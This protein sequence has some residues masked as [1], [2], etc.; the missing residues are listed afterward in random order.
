MYKRFMAFLLTFTLLPSLVPGISVFAAGTTVQ[1]P[2]I[3][4]DVPDV[5]IIRVGDAYYMTST[6]MHMNP[7]VPIMKSTDLVNWEIVNYAYDILAANDKQALLNG[8]NEYGQGS[9]ASALRYNKGKFYIV[10]GSLATGKSYIFQTENIEK[11]PWTSTTLNQYYHDPSLLFD[12]DGRVY[13]IYGGGDIWATE[14]TPDATAIKSGGLNKVIIPNASAAA[15]GWTGKGLNAE[16]SH[17]QKINGKYYVFNI[18]W[19]EG[20]MRTQ[21]VH[22]ADS[23]DGT[24]EGKT[25]LKNNGIAQGGI[26]DTPDG[27]WYGVLFKDNGAV[28]RIPYIIPATWQDGWPVFGDTQDTG[29]ST[30]NMN[31][32]IVKSDEFN[33]RADKVGAYHT[34]VNNPQTT[35][36]S[37]TLLDPSK[38][39]KLITDGDF[40]SGTGSW[41]NFGSESLSTVT[42]NNGPKALFVTGRTATGDGPKQDVTGSVY[43]GR[44]YNFSAKIKYGSEGDATPA[45]KVFNFDLEANSTQA[46]P[47]ESIIVGSGTINKGEWGTISGTITI[48]ADKSISNPFIFIETPWTA[49]PDANNDLMNFYVDDVSLVDTSDPTNTN[50]IA[51]SDFENGNTDSW[52][53]YG[54]A[55]LSAVGGDSSYL[56]VTDRNTTAGP[57]HFLN[58]IQAGHTY[59][60]STKVKYGSDGDATPA[61]KDFLFSIE[62]NSKQERPWESVLNKSTTMTKGA[63]GTI[64]G[65]FTIPATASVDTPFIFIETPWAAT[66]DKNN[67]L[68]DFCVDDI[69]FVDITPDPNIIVNG[70][71]ENGQN[72]WTAHDNNVTLSITNQMYNSGTNSILASERK[73]TA[74]SP[75]QILTGKLTAGHKYH[76]SA[77]VRYD[78]PLAPTEKKFNMDF[79]DG[80]DWTTIKVM[81]SNT[82]KKGEWGTIEGNYTIPS[83]QTLVAPSIFFETDW[84]P[85]PDPHNDLMDF[86]ID[87]VSMIDVTPADTEQTLENESN[88]SN[89]DLVWQWNHNPDNTKWSLTDRPG[90][91]RITTG[92]ISNDIHNAKNTLTQ[93]TFGPESS[94]SIAID[95]SNMKDGDYAGLAAF[96]YYY[97]YVGVKMSGTTK[98]IVMVRG[99]SNDSNVKS[100][101]VEVASIPIEQNR[102]YFKVECD[103][104]NMADN[105][106]FYYSLDGNTWTSIGEPLHMNYYSSHFMGYRFG[107]FNYATKTI[108]GYVDFDY[109]RV[110]NKMTGTT[111]TTALN[112]SLADVP[113]VTGAQNVEFT[114]PVK[115]DALPAGT[116]SSIAVPLNIP[117]YLTVTGVDFNST[118]ITGTTSYT[119]S[120]NQLMLNVSGSNVN[121]A[122]NNSDNLFA[123]IKLKVALFV[124]IDTT[125][126]IT[127]D[128]INVE[129]GDVV[130]NVNNA[131]AN[132]E[133]KALNTGAIEKVPGYANPLITH[134]YGADPYA[135]VYNGRV[136]VYMTSDA[137]E[138]NTDGTIKQNSYSKINTITV[139][140]S[141]DMVNW[142]DHGEIPVAGPNGVAKWAG[143]S[144]APAA[145]HKTINGKEKF[146]LYFANPGDGIGVLTAD[147]P[148]GPWSDPLGHTMVTQETP[149]VAG[150]TWLFDPAVLVDDDGTGYLYV[151]GGVPNEQDPASVA[152]PKTTRVLKLGDDMISIVGNAQTIDAPYMFEDSGIH[153]YNGKYYYSYCI[154][155]SLTHPQDYPIANI[156]YM[157]SDSPMGPFTYAGHFLKNPGDFFGIVGNNHHSVFQF[158]NQW[159]VIYHSQNLN[160]AILGVDKGYRSSNINKLEY[161][162][163]GQIK[164]VQG[165]L[166]GAVQIANVDPYQRTEA[167]TIAW[168]KGITTEVSSAADG[169]VSNL[170]V[171]GIDNGDWLAVSNAD[172]GDNGAKSFKAN[173]AST[174]GGKIEI[175]LDSPEGQ[176]IGT[177]NV[178]PTGGAQTWQ[179]V[180]TDVTDVKGVHSIFF[181]F[182]GAG[183]NLFN[184]DYWQFIKAKATAITSVQ[185]VMDPTS[186]AK[187]KSAALTLTVKDQ[188]GA[189]MELGDATVAYTSGN[190][191]VAAVYNG[192]VTGIEAGI[193]KITAAVTTTDGRV[194]ESNPVTVEVLPILESVS[195]S[196]SKSLLGT[197]FTAQ[198]TVKGTMTGDEQA[199]LSKANIVYSSN[200]VQIAFVDPAGIVHPVSDGSVAIKAAVT[201]NGITREGSIDLA[202]DA[203]KPEYELTVNGTVLKDGGTFEDHLGIDF[204][205]WDSLSGLASAKVTVDGKEYP[206]APAVGSGV[207]IPMAGNLG[208]HSLTVVIEDLAGNKVENHIAFE[209]TTGIESMKQLMD[210][211]VKEG[212]LKGSLTSQLSNNLD[213]AQH[214]L[215]I[216]KPDQAAKHM[217]DFVKHLNNEALGNDSANQVKTVLN[218]DAQQLIQQWNSADT[219]K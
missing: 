108:G 19:P 214:Q 63:W 219:T 91:L 103:F 208:S 8:E 43:A 151:G 25:V 174:V 57:R 185:L 172:F 4:A 41:T 45:T 179:T 139:I 80:D 211:Y 12:D 109:F 126:Q 201:L 13:L 2:V 100:T 188:L 199:D 98:S 215:D 30:G 171:T 64:T 66:P 93:R 36:T 9:W 136:Y 56:S 158:N 78:D 46:A 94:G 68:M 92:R 70:G 143:L 39:K 200:D 196:T 120:N 49:T 31:F 40:E 82:I 58:G 218:A 87:D 189:A 209:V 121:F 127:I 169:P 26:I 181:K 106:Y 186:L 60:F 137:Y 84:V 159:Y 123:T 48:P 118:N 14:L 37:G 128:Y 144:W 164:E 61:T 161:Y 207:Q 170:N 107:L 190:P 95:V 104:K 205:A 75:Q 117:K 182:V 89:L 175:H 113:N 162:D 27:K 47:W 62:V 34:V 111:A 73:A 6:T 180:E 192:I 178:S 132:I 115:M 154:N 135:M 24:Y 51:N 17:I 79:Q 7:G 177:L 157:M 55:Q 38:G 67:D 112:A 32:N 76:F 11:G 204:H 173:V 149:G 116:Y 54:S 114:V 96:Q 184:V 59:Y 52:I 1:N 10:V 105:A 86:Y 195:V 99:S 150:V 153:K 168:N 110:N 138:Y 202:V 165:N 102:V 167:E 133:L 145:A 134:K 206:A 140:S 193:A 148:I 44:T 213:Q 210:R 77:K 35:T 141:A 131:V 166:E 216:G 65:T 16:G 88:G 50:I 97:G 129:G 33:Q 81:G 142:T 130:Y 5:D 147:S 152:N 191:E 197:G 156:G 217:E 163:N 176:L 53:K 71:F 183:T 3:W 125:Q 85:N 29:I 18:A 15:T 119:Y 20:S 72:P 187:T 28:G 23:I 69:S 198:L 22:R 42:E 194:V 74:G 124:P 122:N 21:L 90:Y 101:P 160:K 146:F 83:D 212:L 155:W 203:T